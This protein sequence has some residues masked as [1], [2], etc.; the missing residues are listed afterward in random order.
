MIAKNNHKKLS[1]LAICQLT[2]DIK[3]GRVVLSAS[4]CLLGH[5][6]PQAGINFHAIEFPEVVVKIKDSP[7]I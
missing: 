2:G 7:V 3:H 4:N 1:F 5:L 6:V